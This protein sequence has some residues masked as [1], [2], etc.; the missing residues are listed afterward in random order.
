MPARGLCEPGTTKASIVE[1]GQAQPDEL[2]VPV[3]F[4]N[5]SLADSSKRRSRVC[6]VSL[7]RQT[8][9]STM[10]AR[11]RTLTQTRVFLKLFFA[12]AARVGV[13]RPAGLLWDCMKQPSGC[14]VCTCDNQTQRLELLKPE[15][16]PSPIIV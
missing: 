14:R 1:F 5:G 3:S 10:A 4:S 13:E 12:V 8:E 16:T 2:H 9:S 15:A 7:R 6:S 11:D